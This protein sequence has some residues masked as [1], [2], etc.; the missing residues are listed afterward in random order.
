MTSCA[1]DQTGNDW[2][3]KEKAGFHGVHQAGTC[4]GHNPEHEVTDIPSQN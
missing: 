1:F 4:N 2:S 3:V